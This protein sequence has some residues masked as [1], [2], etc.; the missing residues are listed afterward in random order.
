MRWSCTTTVS[1]GVTTFVL[2]LMLH[3]ATVSDSTVST[4]LRDK[5]AYYT[6]A[7][8]S[9]TDVDEYKPGRYYD[10]DFDVPPFDHPDMGNHRHLMESNGLNI[11]KVAVLLETR[12]LPHLV[13]LILHNINNM[14]SD[15]PFRIYNSVDNQEMLFTNPE[16]LA[17]MAIGK[18]TVVPIYQRFDDFMA[19]VRV[20]RYLTSRKFWKNLSPAKKVLFFQSDA[21]IC[22]QSTKSIEDYM[23][24]DWI[25]APIGPG[26]SPDTL[27]EGEIWMN[28]G[29]SLRDR[30]VMLDI[31]DP[32]KYPWTSSYISETDRGL[33]TAEDQ[34]F[35][36]RM[37]EIGAK[38][39]SLEVAK[40][41][42]V[43]TVAY[44]TPWSTHKAWQYLNE[45]DLPKLEAFCPESTLVRG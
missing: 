16:I 41:F 37:Y 26:W 39:P 1:A 3:L 42:G 40:T 5:I 12:P 24:Y 38:L 21:I 43:E 32:Q 28:G 44:E 18:I 14:P 33:I 13:P 20:G 9:M 4:A 2:I 45:A 27:R 34:Y 10:E 11:S 19:W 8:K 31:L 36:K 7:S 30:E 23:E 22:S 29:I 17:Y 15:W 35:C 6:G 25:G